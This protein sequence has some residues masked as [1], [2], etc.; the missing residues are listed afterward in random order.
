MKESGTYIMQYDQVNIQ[1]KSI[2]EVAR[3]LGISRN[4][5]RKFRGILRFYSLLISFGNPIHQII[6]YST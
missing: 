4:T 1:E 2:P 5:I 3:E 6:S